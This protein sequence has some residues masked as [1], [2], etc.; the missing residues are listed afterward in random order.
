MPCP[1]LRG[2]ILVTE[3]PEFPITSILAEGKG[4]VFYRKYVGCCW[5]RFW[6][7]DLRGSGGTIYEV[8]KRC[9]NTG[10]EQWQLATG[11][12]GWQDLQAILLWSQF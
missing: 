1:R 7:R 10:G 9:L 8:R 4:G 6:Y 11:F 2:R 5:C 12:Q 3:A